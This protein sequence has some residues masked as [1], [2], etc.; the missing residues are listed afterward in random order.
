MPL[1]GGRGKMFSDV[2]TEF[3]LRPKVTLRNT[4]FLLSA[5]IY[6]PARDRPQARSYG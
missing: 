1:P 6:N 3:P 5:R 2:N 4:V